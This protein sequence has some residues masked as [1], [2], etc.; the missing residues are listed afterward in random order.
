MK[1][2]P[3]NVMFFCEV[4]PPKGGETPIGPSWRVA[5]E[6]TEIHFQS[7]P[8]AHGILYGKRLAGVSGKF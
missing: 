4:P 7:P 6:R 8:S 2:Y 3:E 1:G 5:G